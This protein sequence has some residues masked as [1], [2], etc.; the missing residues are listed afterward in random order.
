MFAIMMYLIFFLFFTP[1]N[2][3][4]N[5]VMAVATPTDTTYYNF[6]LSQ[7]GEKL[8]GSGIVVYSLD[9][10]KVTGTYKHPNVSL[11]FISDKWESQVKVEVVSDDL[12]YA[13]NY[14]HK[15]IIKRN[16][17]LE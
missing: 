8:T 3:S 5:W 9:K 14:K 17:L 4:G 10:Y 6:K 11:T 1:Q 13:V 7:N 16:Y 2:L 12:L 15:V